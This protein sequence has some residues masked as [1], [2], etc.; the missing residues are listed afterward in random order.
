M[1][2]IAI[3]VVAVLGIMALG[4]TRATYAQPDTVTVNLTE[5]NN[6]G[7][8]GTATLTAH[9]D[10]TMVVVNI[11]GGSS[12]PQ[13]AHIH[14]GTCA[15]L[16]PKP[17]YPLTSLVNGTSETT[18]P[19]SLS[20]LVNGTFAINVH[21]SG[22]EASVYV[23]CGD[24]PNMFASGGASGGGTTGGEMGGGETVGM[25]RTGSPDLTLVALLALLGASLTG[26]G[27]KLARRKA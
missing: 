12:T 13:P 20:Q 27:L 2:K 18:V 22:P 3:L 11:S 1:K 17:I 21:K 10:T 19:V 4:G 15:T 24:I 5:E 25:P 7:Q 16:D 23:S 9:G 14:P 6:S 26:V 8:N